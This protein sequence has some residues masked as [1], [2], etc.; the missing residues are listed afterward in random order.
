M[1]LIFVVVIIITPSKVQLKDIFGLF[2][3]WIFTMGTLTS[4]TPG[5]QRT[6]ILTGGDEVISNVATI[7]YSSFIPAFKS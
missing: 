2:L 6:P 3:P 7:L 5:V 1:P 4:P